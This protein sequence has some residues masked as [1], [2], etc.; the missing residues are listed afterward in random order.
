MIFNRFSKFQPKPFTIWESLL[1]AGPWK[2]W[3]F[4][5]IPSVR[6]KHPRKT[7]DLAMRRLAM[8]GGGTGQNSGT[9]LVFQAG[10]GS[11]GEE[12]LTT[13]RFGSKLGLQGRWWGG[14]AE[15]C[16]FGRWS[17]FSGETTTTTE[18]LMVVGAHVDAR[19]GSGV[20]GWRWNRAE[21]GVVGG[22]CHGGHGG[23][24]CCHARAGRKDGDLI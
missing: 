2:F 17:G 12:E 5:N 18:Q 11:W 10:E 20:F 3:F 22:G 21:E 24:R 4:T 7:Q 14:V 19:G 9:S 13:A 16:G 6:T 15:S 1:P 23:R 8:E